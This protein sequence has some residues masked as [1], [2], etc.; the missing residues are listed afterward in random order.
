M[1]EDGLLPENQTALIL[2]GG[3]AFHDYEGFASLGERERLVQDLG[4]K[5]VMLLRNHG[6]LTM[7]GSVAEAF[8]SMYYLENAC[9]IQV[10]ALG[11]NLPL[12]KVAPSVVDAFEKK[13]AIPA[14]SRM[15]RDLVWPAL[16]RKL[17][18]MDPNWRG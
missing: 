16:L 11:M 17:D 8:T 5:N 14:V 15:G 13:S 6:T 7:G 4:D 3:I 10:R 12:H 2:C 9:T 18:R 1:C